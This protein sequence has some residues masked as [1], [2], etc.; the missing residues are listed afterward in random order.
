MRAL[1]VI[2]VAF[3]MV[4]A[5]AFQGPAAFG[6]QAD[7]IT[8]MPKILGA[9][10]VV[11]LMTGI[12]GAAVVLIVRLSLEL[13]PRQFS[14]AGVVLELEKRLREGRPAE[15][16]GY[17]RSLHAPFATVACAVLECR[18][19]DRGAG[20]ARLEEMTASAE[21]S[22]LEPIR[23]RI[24]YLQ[25]LAAAVL[26]LALFGA[27]VALLDAF[28]PL[29]LDLTKARPL[30]LAKGLAHVWTLVMMG[31]SIAIPAVAACACFRGLL[32]EAHRRLHRTATDV[33]ALLNK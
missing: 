14:D 15:A 33:V 10:A 9:G 4:L 12:A 28:G 24:R 22:L 5:S 19:R 2:V 23:R 21:A 7:E 30:Q 25:D 32:T 29:S 27:M 31:V 18:L 13:R 1:T 11:C 6:D 16:L 8:F 26:M 17:C 20:I 3:V